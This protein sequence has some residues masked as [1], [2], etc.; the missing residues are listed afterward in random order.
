M[1]AAAVMP[2]LLRLE[3]DSGLNRFFFARHLCH[4]L[5]GPPAGHRKVGPETPSTGFPVGLWM[6]RKASS[7]AVPFFPAGLTG[8]NV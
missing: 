6:T 8:S 2:R 1:L 3:H 4:Q 5:Q 7:L